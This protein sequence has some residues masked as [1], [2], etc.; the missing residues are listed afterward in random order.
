MKAPWEYLD[1]L[2][3]IVYV[4]DVKSNE[5]LYMNRYAMQAFSLQKEQEYLGKKCY[6]LLQ[7]LSK[8]CIF[9]NTFRLE[10]GKFEEW[11]YSN[12]ILQ[13]TFLLKDTLITWEGKICR[14]EIAIKADRKTLSQN[15]FLY[16]ETMIN[17][18]MLQS[19]SM[20]DPDEAL[21]TILDFFGKRLKCSRIDL[22]EMQSAEALLLSYS[23]RPGGIGRAGKICQT[24][25]IR[26]LKEW[27]ETLRHNEP[28]ILTDMKRLR[29]ENPE[30]AETFEI[31][32]CSVLLL[33][34][35]IYHHKVIGA[36]RIDDPEEEFLRNAAEIGKML[37]HFV[38]SI[39]ERRDLI[40]HLKR[41]SYHDQ[42][43]G[44]LN[45][46]ALEERMKGGDF[47]KA[48]GILECDIVGLKN[49]NDL[50]GHEAGDNTIRRVCQTLLSVFST[51][52][53][54][55]MGGDE[56]L[57]VCDCETE[58]EFEIQIELLRRKIAENNCIL[59]IGSVWSGKGK[60]DFNSLL[61]IAD[62]KMYLEKEAYYAQRDPVTGRRRKRR[63][64]S[65]TGKTGLQKR[66]DSFL[67][68]IRNYYFDSEFFFR[69]VLLE[70]GSTYIF[71]GDMEKNLYYISD[72]LKKDFDFEDN[73]VYDFITLLEQRIH[74]EDRQRHIEDGKALIAE[75]KT[76]HSIRY[77]IYNRKGEL[78]WI[79]CQGILKWDEKKERPLFFSGNM[80]TLNDMAGMDLTSGIA[81]LTGILKELE[82]SAEENG[83]K[84]I[85]LCFSLNNFASINQ[86]LGRQKGDAIIWETLFQMEKEMGNDFRII[87]LSGVS[88]MA[89]SQ[90]THD[91][92][93]AA[94]IIRRTVKEIYQKYDIPI[95]YPCSIGVLKYPQDGADAKQLMENAVIVLSRA[96]TSTGTRFA[97]FSPEMAQGYQEETEIDMALNECIN[98][99]FKGF[100]ITVQP[101]VTADDGIIFGGEALLRW[102]FKGQDIP[103][104]RFIPIL[105]QSGLIIP[106]G[107]WVI[108][109]A[110]QFCG[111]IIQFF[112][113]FRLSVN[114]SYI[115][116]M[117]Q[118][119][120][121][122]ITK[123]L[124]NCH[125]PGKN[126]VLELTET[127]A[128]EMPEQLTEFIQKCREIGIGFALDDFGTAYSSLQMLIKYS[129][130]LVKLDR[131]LTREIA[132][133][134][135]KMNFIMSIIYACHK[136][137]KRVC[138]E[139]VEKE[140]E[141][142]AVRQ[143]DCDYIQ[144]FYFYKPLE[145]EDFLEIL[146][147]EKRNLDEK[148]QEKGFGA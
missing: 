136:F 59:S 98:H 126:I 8:V 81:G 118:E 67:D 130:D 142:I 109:Q 37:S 127:H 143:T 21:Q 116:I 50:Q 68:Y 55:R 124:T 66:E 44:V 103:P 4:I 20:A 112:P 40:R 93:K 97:E 128:D 80:I 131:T 31:S 35:L 96:K 42:L 5:L 53:V 119:F 95:I 23:W 1:G 113:D 146:K 139:G 110:I 73:L 133:S 65:Q 76:R 25:S 61:K 34:P 105:E 102:K 111:K 115:Q 2:N 12:P 72:N 39:L 92:E 99:H 90:N 3:E 106:L 108:L 51:S 144:G 87:R 64:S 78:V 121:P 49:I 6:S 138:M 16:F 38:V 54:Y 134:R 75:K 132:S 45:R 77:Q 125:V 19:H 74:E 94:Q 46:H 58:N 83:V 135:E 129:S 101:Q 52:E 43:T 7:G 62:E 10:E 100:R 140:E 56:F 48:V 18:C 82:E 86:L 32:E 30:A 69:S 9:C 22:Y 79:Q 15:G 70:E 91:A 47:D 137:G 24:G 147:K 148:R 29:Q 14:M 84:L 17:D 41:L 33:I 13:S 63:E 57:A 71:C 36:L 27:Y 117:D 120:L 26:Y 107:K 114:V 89:V 11:S 60:K 122:F 145:T 85:L 123:V 104:S 88:F 141:L 28:L